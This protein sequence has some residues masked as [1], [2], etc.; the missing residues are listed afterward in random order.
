MVA[1]I[2]M[3]MVHTDLNAGDMGEGGSRIRPEGVL[4][5]LPPRQST[6]GP[7]VQG[8][9]KFV[10]GVFRPHPIISRT[11]APPL[12][13]AAPGPV[14]ARHGDTVMV[15]ERI[16]CQEQARIEETPEELRTTLV[17]LKQRPGDQFFQLEMLRF[18]VH[19]SPKRGTRTLAPLTG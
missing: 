16:R 19:F 9:S 14:I 5:H 12:K 18:V 11:E 7:E 17:R 4:L 10:L 3:E 8:P 13:P 1:D 6:T 2:E 15:P